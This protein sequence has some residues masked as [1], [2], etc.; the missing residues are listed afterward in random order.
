[1]LC[2]RCHVAMTNHGRIATKAQSRPEPRSA[3]SSRSR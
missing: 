3:S 2:H 1:V